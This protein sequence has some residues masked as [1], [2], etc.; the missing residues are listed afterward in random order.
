MTT[1]LSKLNFRDLGGLRS[2]S[3]HVV[4]KGVIYRSE[5]PA[6]YSA[7]HRDELAALGVRTVCDLRSEAERA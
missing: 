7:A 4:K 5:G 1:E 2:R 6:N 3:G